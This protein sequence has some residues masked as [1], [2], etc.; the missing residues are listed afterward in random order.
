MIWLLLAAHV[1]GLVATGALAPM[2]GR[3][4]F[5]V[6]AL[7]PLAWL[8]H[9]RLYVPVVLRGGSLAIAAM[10]AVWLVERAVLGA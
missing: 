8:A 3:R 6:A 4:V 5:Y 2:L 9:R 1:V 10:G 7:A